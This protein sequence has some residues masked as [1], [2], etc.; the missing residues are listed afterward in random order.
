M[1]PS[2]PTILTG[3]IVL[4][5]TMAYLIGIKILC[6]A[7][8]KVVFNNRKCE[9]FFESNLILLGYKDPTTN[10]WTLPLSHKEVANTTPK[11]VFGEP[12]QCAHAA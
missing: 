4:Y 6:K 7:G 11:S 1:I 5:I 9:V 8:C 10:L 2:L 3:H 12:P